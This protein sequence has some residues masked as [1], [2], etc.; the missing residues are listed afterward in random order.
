M[1]SA[2]QARGLFG[3]FCKLVFGT[4]HDRRHIGCVGKFEDSKSI[5]L[6]VSRFLR[7]CKFRVSEPIKGTQNESYSLSLP[8]KV[9]HSLVSA[10]HSIDV[11]VRTLTHHPDATAVEG[12][13]K[14]LLE[15]PSP[16]SSAS[17]FVLCSKF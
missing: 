4:F 17:S 12:T 3:T 14:G 9:F 10:D 16:A 11:M 13:S 15:R 8:A 2:G 1:P 7:T 6:A 5:R